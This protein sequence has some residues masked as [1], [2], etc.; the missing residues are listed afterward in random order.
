MEKKTVKM[1][2][3]VLYSSYFFNREVLAHYL[4]LR[5]IRMPYFSFGSAEKER[6]YAQLHSVPYQLMTTNNHRG[7]LLFSFLGIEKSV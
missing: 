2:C 7:S 6:I 5:D 4:G 3:Y 1:L